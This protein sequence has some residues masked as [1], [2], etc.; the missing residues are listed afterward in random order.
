MPRVTLERREARKGTILHAARRVF[1]EKGLHGAT[2]HDIAR[3]AG[4]PVG[5]IYTWFANKD[6]L[7][8]A[9]VL[10]A[11]KEET[12][13]VVR[14]VGAAGGNFR[15]RFSR[16][17]AGWY[18]FTIAAPGVPEFL[19]EVWAEATRKPLIRDIVV[20]RRERIV[21]TASLVL[22]EGIAAGEV[23]PDTDVGTTARALANLLDGIVLERL[24]GVAIDRAEVERRALL[25]LRS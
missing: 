4:V 11:N 5:T 24:E 13:A 23:P 21:T 7:I 3:A 1:V 16:A 2:T 9:S 10:A 6:E 8:R 15:E 18:D 12:D 17:I 14:D 22:A 19:A 25:L 20:R